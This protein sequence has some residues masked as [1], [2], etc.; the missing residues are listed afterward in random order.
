MTDVNTKDLPIEVLNTLEDNLRR[1]CILTKNEN[2]I[3]VVTSPYL[4]TVNSY[5]NTVLGKEV[6]EKIGDEGLARFVIMGGSILLFDPKITKLDLF[7]SIN[8]LSTK[9][10][11]WQLEK[12]N[13]DNTIGW[14]Q[15]FFPIAQKLQ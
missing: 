14:I 6:K 8:M 2:G 10:N 15:Y 12:S 11:K 7:H 5:T 9:I 13:Y 1:V 3:L 4:K